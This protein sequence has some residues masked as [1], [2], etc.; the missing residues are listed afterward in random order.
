METH[1]FKM[2]VLRIKGPQS[3]NSLITASK[4]TFY[5]F[6]PL[7]Y[8]QDVTQKKPRENDPYVTGIKS[9]CLM[10]SDTL[11]KCPRDIRPDPAK[12]PNRTDQN[13]PRKG[14]KGSSVK[15]GLSEKRFL[16]PR[17]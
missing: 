7:P 10:H 8:K 11:W 5:F 12:D 9:Y 15:E 17:E 4:M 14:N 2:K 6:S 1:R 16:E 3:P 13:S